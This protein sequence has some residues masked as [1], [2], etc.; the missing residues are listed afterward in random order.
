[1][2]ENSEIYSEAQEAVLLNLLMSAVT[3]DGTL[4]GNTDEESACDALL[5][6]V[7]EVAIPDGNDTAREIRKN[8]IC[9]GSAGSMTETCYLRESCHS[10][11]I[12]NQSQDINLF[13][14]HVIVSPADAGRE[15]LLI[16]DVC[17]A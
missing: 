6:A 11:H 2:N 3:K 9:G 10:V 8:S 1:M 14:L 4:V 13:Q 7:N 15:F 16:R 12:Y 17:D 5:T